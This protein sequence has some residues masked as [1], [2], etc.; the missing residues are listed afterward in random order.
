MNFIK[1]SIKII[2][3]LQLSN[4]GIL[5]TPLNGAYPY[6][7]VRDGVIMTKALNSVG[8]YKN[9]EKFYYFLAENTK[10]GQYKEIFHRYNKSGLP[11][12]TRKEQHDNTG[13]LLHGIY[14]TYLHNQDE[15]F[16]ENM[17][18]LI[19]KCCKFIFNFSKEGLVHTETSVHELYRLERGYELWANCSCCRGLYDA[20]E[21]A[22]ILKKKKEREKWEKKAG[23]LHKNIKSRLFNKR[24]GLYEKNLKCPRVSDISQVAPFYF[25]LED[26]KRILRKTLAHLK[27][28]LWYK[29][30]GGFR[31]FKKFEV[32]KD[33]HW[34][35]GGSGGWT[36]FTAMMAKLYKK[37]GDRKNYNSCKRWLDKTA[38]RTSG[39]LPEHVATK[40]EYD[41][42][43]QN[44]I[45]FNN[46]ILKGMRKT[47]KLNRKF[48]KNG[49]D[50]VYWG[51]PLG[52]AHAEY[53]LM[54]GE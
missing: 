47:E 40:Q 4:G 32:C 18:G 25:K 23:Q 29:E 39:L 49:E 33:W 13:L 22:R 5:S 12:V 28:E 3:S 30:G 19:I 38:S 36:A 35:T 26:N 10:P 45:E 24:T 31:R 43:K 15:E 50:L 17:W 16:L 54:N 21:I 6:V 46:R 7:Y 27:K 52:W 11:Y 2:K 20:A 9:S 42:W 37:I 51:I 1:K 34:Y 44:E 53:I 41:L 48:K 8:D 14:D